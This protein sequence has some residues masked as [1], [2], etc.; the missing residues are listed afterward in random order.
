MRKPNAFLIG[1]LENEQAD[2][3]HLLPWVQ[4]SLAALA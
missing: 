4:E 1:L 3:E 2:F